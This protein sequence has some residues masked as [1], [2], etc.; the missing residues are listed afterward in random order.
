M[1]N[2]Y[3]TTQFI[4][5]N[6]DYNSCRNLHLVYQTYSKI[7]VKNCVYRIPQWNPLNF[8]NGLVLLCYLVTLLLNKLITL[9]LLYLGW[10]WYR[11]AFSYCAKSIIRGI[12]SENMPLVEFFFFLDY[13]NYLVALNVLNIL[14]LWYGILDIRNALYWA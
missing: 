6:K 14:Q 4:T 2:Y 5:S 7:K 8:G 11:W 10:W 9:P 1:F 13:L 3:I 12:S